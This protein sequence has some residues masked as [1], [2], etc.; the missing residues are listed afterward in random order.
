MTKLE[1]LQ[2]KLTATRV[3]MGVIEA[4]HG[5]GCGHPGVR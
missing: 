3:R 5:A 1:T 4:T 2:L